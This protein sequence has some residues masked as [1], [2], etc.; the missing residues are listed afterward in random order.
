MYIVQ[1]VETEQIYK[2]KYSDI[3][4][5]EDAL[6]GCKVRITFEDADIV[7]TQYHGT[8]INYYIFS[9]FIIEEFIY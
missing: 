1:D 2:L 3:L 8:V 9:I 4:K 5:N 6:V 7:D